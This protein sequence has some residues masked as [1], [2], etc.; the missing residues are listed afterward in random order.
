V[1]KKEE[2]PAFSFLPGEKTEKPDIV[3]AVDDGFDASGKGPAQGEGPETETG[4][5]ALEMRVR[6]P[7]GGAE[8]GSPFPSRAGA[9]DGGMYFLFATPVLFKIEI[10]QKSDPVNEAFP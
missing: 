3:A 4:R 10:E 9:C 8:R 7:G 2:A 6:G 5:H 1:E